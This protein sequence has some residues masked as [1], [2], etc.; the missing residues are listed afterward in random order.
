M[1]EQKPNEQNSFNPFA[2]AETPSNSYAGQTPNNPSDFTGQTHATP[3]WDAPAGA[4]VDEASSK[5]AQFPRF[6]NAKL[7]PQGAGAGA[8]D[9][10]KRM[11]DAKSNGWGAQLIGFFTAHKA[12][13][14]IVLAVVALFAAGSYAARFSGPN[15]RTE[16]SAAVSQQTVQDNDDTNVFDIK[17]D[18]TGIVILENAGDDSVFLADVS[19]GSSITK[20]AMPGEGITHLARKALA[21]YLAEEGKSLSSE[22]KIYAEDYVQNMTGD[23]WL[24]IG[25]KLSFSRELL[26]DAAQAAE[27]L[28]DWQI[29]NL[30]Q[31]TSQVSLL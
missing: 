18:K 3:A 14:A 27:G 30:K 17:L 24:D 9:I 5:Q 10:R 26:R 19:D 29:E 11:E 25:Q 6:N 16:S 28:Q 8:A 22:Q 2:S 4:S 31:Y 7:D 1:E 20:T 13:I 15:D 23:E 21:D 12:R